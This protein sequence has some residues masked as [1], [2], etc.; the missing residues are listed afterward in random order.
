[1]L[2][3]KII[4]CLCCL[5]FVNCN[6]PQMTQ[7]TEL[8][9]EKV[10]TFDS[11][12]TNSNSIIIDNDT[13]M[14]LENIKIDTVIFKAVS[15]KSN[16]IF[17]KV[18]FEDG[19]N[20]G[21]RSYDNI[22]KVYIFSKQLH[23]LILQKIN[24]TT[25]ILSLKE[26]CK[27]NPL[28]YQNLVL[29]QDRGCCIKVINT[30]NF[31]TIW[32]IPT[33]GFSISQPI[34]EDRNAII[35]LNDNTLISVDFI[36]G[37]ENWRYKSN[38]GLHIGSVYGS[39][40]EQVFILTTDLKDNIEI[41]A[42]D[43]TN[44]KLLIHKKLKERIDV[45]NTSNVVIGNKLY[46]KGYDNVFVYDLKSFEKLN[47]FN[48]KDLSNTKLVKYNTKILFSTDKDKKLFY[49]ENEELKEIQSK[50]KIHDIILDSSDNIYIFSYPQLYKARLLVYQS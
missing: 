11:N 36:T 37:K 17:Q 44:G 27:I 12:F 9:L 19:Y 31:K 2:L 10:Y 4:V 48:I 43:I 24:G 29:F 6:T 32:T 14:F 45:W 39:N 13:L 41:E 26:T 38:T 8:Q 49:I 40:Q 1:M 33:G 20:L 42:I 7:N 35:L 30:E 21:N 28:I 22:H 23:S 16:Q 46:C 34:L 47:E 5:I 18:Y 25:Q 3:K 50:I 15:I